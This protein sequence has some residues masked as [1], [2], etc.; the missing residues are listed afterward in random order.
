MEHRVDGD[1]RELA[2]DMEEWSVKL[3][4]KI[5]LTR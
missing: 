4:K 3:S 1:S 2:E 5:Q